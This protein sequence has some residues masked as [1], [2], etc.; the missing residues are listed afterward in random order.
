M[1][2]K[3]TMVLLAIMFLG[4][5]AFAGGILTNTNQSVNFLRNP[6][7]DAAIGLDG[8]Y[9]NPAGVAFLSDGLHLGFNWQY[10][11]QTRTITSTNPLFALGA[12]N[13]GL[14]TK[15]FEG[16]ANA[17]FIPSLQAAYNKNNWSFQFNFSVPGGG[18]KCE[19]DK[20]I[21]SF[22]TVV[23]SIASLLKD[24]SEE[25]NNQFFQLNQSLQKFPVQL[26][27]ASVPNVTGY[28]VDG[29]MKGQQYYFGFQLG[30]ARKINE[31]LSVYAGLRLLYGTASYEA[32]LNNI[33]VMNGADGMTLTDYF[34]GVNNGFN[35][36]GKNVATCSQL[37]KDNIQTVNNAIDQYVTAYMNQGMTQEQAM[38]QPQI[39]QL[40]Q[41]GQQL[42]AVGETLQETGQNLQEN[43]QK[44]AASA[45]TL[46]P[47]VNGVNLK[48]DQSG[49]GIAPVIGIDYKIG[50]FNLAAKYEFKTRMRMKNDSDLKEATVISSMNK[51]V[52]GTS[53]PEDSPAL[54]A[55]GAQWE[56][57]PGVRLNLGYHH[58][59]DK[60]AHWYE[61]SEK[62]LD[63]DTNEYLAGAEWDITKK[64]Q[65]SGGVQLTRYGLSDAYMNDMSFVVNSWTFGLGVGYQVTDKVKVNAAYFQTNYE[66]YD[67]NMPEQNMS[68]L[69]L[70]I[71][72]GKNSFTRTNR[73]VGLGVEVTI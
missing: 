13:N 43:G 6:A 16:V 54:L 1:M 45:E 36:A 56:M 33:R 20:G 60:S 14:T 62:L 32:R 70:T 10:A 21:G 59:F 11:H 31:H 29:Y 42:K 67:M 25:I 12:K 72:E 49:W 71:P 8:V 64:L 19:F 23:G 4:N 22:E 28:D 9:S 37:V 18:G 40:V 34:M 5:T 55:L 51:Y 35:N 27:D 47:Y 61:H 57:T 66:N 69:G 17:P 73:V 50:N 63:G 26:L 44:L 39:Q 46:A 2:K 7:R 30:V 65:V 68:G 15:E 52:N 48:S 58:F 53:V 38:Q 41:Q 24:K 3:I